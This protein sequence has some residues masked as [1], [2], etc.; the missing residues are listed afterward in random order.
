M[1]PP[2]RITM[3]QHSVLF[4]LLIGIVTVIG[5]LTG[6]GCANIIPPMGGPRDS[7]PPVLVSARPADSS[8]NFT[9]KRIVFEFNEYVQLDNI[10]QNLLV[11]P[12]PK[13]N[14][15]VESRLRT[16]TVTI[17][18]TLEPGTTYSINFGNAIKDVNEGNPYTDFTYLFSTGA[19]LDSMKLSGK[20]VM[21]ETGKSDSTLIVMLHTSTD[22]SAVIKINP[23]YIAR[24][25]RNGEFNFYNLPPATYSIYALQDEGGQ[26]K[27]SSTEQLFGFLDSTVTTSTKPTPVTIYAFKEEKKPEAKPATPARPQ[28]NRGNTQQRDNR[29]KIGTNLSNSE[30]D[31]LGNL[32][33]AFTPAPLKSFD[34]AKVLFTNEQYQPLTGYYYIRDTSMEKITLVYKW[35]PATKYNLI[36]DKEFAEDTLGNKIPRTDTIAF[37]TKKENEYGEM[38]LRLLNLDMSKNPVLQFVQSDQVRYSFPLTGREFNRP[39]FQ[40]GEYDLRL[41]FDENKNGK[42]DAGEFFGK[43]QQPEKV[44]PIPRKLTVKANWD[45]VVDITL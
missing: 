29:I 17:K 5:S 32:E 38:H 31:L 6:T 22:D 39:L 44:F 37:T 14:P 34:S 7:I 24:T 42:W 9:G 25:N 33:L 21:A 1:Q 13:I 10:Q 12:V 41:L 11:S 26:H 16:V 15:L 23:R 19:S 2:L 36:I 35:A 4:L 18:D 8:K 3:K 43:H 45:N 20:V 40:P 27:Y 28:G 30:Q